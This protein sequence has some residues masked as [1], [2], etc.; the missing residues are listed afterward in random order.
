MQRFYSAISYVPLLILRPARLL[1]AA[2]R[3]NRDREHRTLEASSPQCYSHSRGF[4]S[5]RWAVPRGTWRRLW[6]GRGWILR[7]RRV[8]Y[9][10]WYFFSL[11]SKYFSW[12]KLLSHKFFVRAMCVLGTFHS[13]M[14]VPGFLCHTNFSWGLNVSEKVF[15]KV[16]LR[17]RFFSCRFVL[18]QCTFHKFYSGPTYFSWGL[19]GSQVIFVRAIYIQSTFHAV[20]VISGIS[21]QVYLCSLFWGLFVSQDLFFLFECSIS[22]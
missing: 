17:P 22:Y 10:G 21:H 1:E 12:G 20:L 18:D 6:Q 15:V 2:A 14:F 3:P 4:G 11:C 8:R 5:G 13:V 9:Y 7:G 16:I 19:F